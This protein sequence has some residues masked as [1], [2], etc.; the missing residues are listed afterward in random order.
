VDNPSQAN[1]Q[2][3]QTGIRRLWWSLIKPHVYLKDIGDQRRAQLLSIFTLGLS[4][5][6]ALAIPSTLIMRQRLTAAANVLIPVIFLFLLAYVFSRSQFYGIGSWILVIT[7]S[8]SAY[9]EILGGANIQSSVL[10]NISIA[11]II[12][13]ALLSIREMIIFTMSNAVAPLFL[14][15]LIP[16]AL[17][18]EIWQSIGGIIAIGGLATVVSVVRSNIENNRLQELKASN[19][20]L[21]EIRSTLENRVEERTIEISVSAE[22]TKRRVRQLEAIA[23]IARAIAQ[24]QDVTELLPAITQVIGQRFGFYHVGIFL[25]DDTREYAV[26]RATNSEGGQRMLARGHR[27]R[28]GQTGIVG[29]VA[30]KGEPRISLDVGA[31]AVFFDNPDLPSTRSEMALPLKYGER[32]I[33]VL[34]VQSEGPAAFG[35]QSLDVMTTLTDLVAIAI[36]N[37]RLFGEIQHALIEAQVSY[38]QY[39]RQAWEQLP[40]ETQAS[41]YRY[42]G[43]QVD[44]L[45][46]PLDLPEIQKALHSGKPV[47]ETEKEPVLAVPL[48]LRDEVIGVL[49]IRSNDP[50]RHWTDNELALVQAV[51]DRA[52]IALENARLFEETTRRADRERTVAEITTRIRSAADPQVMLRTALDELKNVLGAGD[53]Q[54]RPYSP[55]SK[56][57]AVESSKRVG[58]TSKSAG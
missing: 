52:A 38:G 7:M 24:L 26:L 29:Y 54:I 25:L 32:V 41:G 13:S 5:L 33:G 36:E 16:N 34:D 8:L 2:T 37:A 50:S 20:E 19:R 11:L 31:D 14:Y 3:A 17:P 46:T 15:L 53:I 45:D 4:V 40:Q 42:S 56:E 10:L 21:N 39:L 57:K 9:G 30:D 55:H 12:G 47:I 22:E 28:V 6:M 23:E 58:K 18:V 43:V 1:P 44:T 49:D 48:K 35:T 51:A 27:L